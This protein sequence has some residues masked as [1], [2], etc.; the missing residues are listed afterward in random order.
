MSNHALIRRAGAL[1]ATLALAVG[2]TLGL[3][4]CGGPKPE[5]VIKQQVQLELDTIKE[6][7]ADTIKAVLGEDEWN[8]L[9][10]SGMDVEAFYN[11]CVKHFSYEEPTVTVDGD[12][13]TVTVNVTN[14][15]L[16]QVF[17][18]WTADALDY[19]GTEEAQNDLA[20]L[21]E[22]GIASKLFEKLYAALGADDAPLKTADVQIDFE[23]DSD[24]SWNPSDE[25]QLS[26]LLFAGVDPSVIG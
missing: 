21:G 20:T 1:F 8:S 26:S 17:E 14:V 12:S 16:V 11:S 13:A 24:G 7:D 25:S 10:S 3:S 22:D 19:A 9:S 18:A 4:A 2:G 6:A 5:E 15:D 23:K